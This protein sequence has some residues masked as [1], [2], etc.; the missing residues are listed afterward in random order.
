[1]AANDL[2]IKAIMETNVIDD[3]EILAGLIR[4]SSRQQTFQLLLKK[5]TPGLY[6]FLRHS[7][8]DHE[9]ADE[10]VQ[11]IF[12]RFWR[13]LDSLKETDR[14]DVALYHIAV[15]TCLPFLAQL[16]E[17]SSEVLTAEQKM[18]FAL[19]QLHE[20]DFYKIATIM[21]S[22]VKQVRENFKTALDHT[23]TKQQPG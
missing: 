9:D 20:F 23:M 6:Y 19:K 18:V 12:V 22:P 17:T 15:E 2:S 10:Q 8:L 16:S 14:L 4:L 5:Y 3:Q 13:T 1:M 21:A 7:G 11:E